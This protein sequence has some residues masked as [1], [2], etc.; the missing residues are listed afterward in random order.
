G[1][2]QYLKTKIRSL[3]PLPTNLSKED[4]VRM[5]SIADAGIT[6]Y[7]A[8]KR[9]VNFLTP[10]SFV[11]VIGAGGGLGHMAVQMLKH[12]SP[13]KIIAIDKKQSGL[14][15]AEKMGADYSVISGSDTGVGEVLKLTGGNGAKVVMDFVGEGEVTTQAL[16]MTQSQG[17]LSVIGYGGKF[18]ETTYDLIIREISVLGNLTGTYPE[19]QEMVNLY[20][21][22]KF[23]VE[24]PVYPLTQAN[25]AL[26]DLAENKYEGRATLVP[27]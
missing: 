9:I 10:G 26:R 17:I 2:A 22:H 25:K 12:M 27:P 24:G 14:E 7:H 19:F 6:A 20:L 16:K 8:V 1:Y 13:A 5:A 21:E 23:K 15:L 4:M 18:E 3:V 11:A